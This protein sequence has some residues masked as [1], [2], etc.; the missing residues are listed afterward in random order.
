MLIVVNIRMECQCS[1]MLYFVGGRCSAS[2]FCLSQSVGYGIRKC[3]AS[4]ARVGKL[5]DGAISVAKGDAM[6][7]QNFS[8]RRIWG[9]DNGRF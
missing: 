1:I 8:D 5:G 7:G 2:G 3:F 4:F 9:I 6:F